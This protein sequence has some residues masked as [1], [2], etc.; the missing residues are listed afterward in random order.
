MLHKIK[1]EEWASLD[2]S[3][4]PSRVQ[5]IEKENEVQIKLRVEN[6]G[7]LPK[8]DGRRVQENLENLG[9]RMEMV[10]LSFSWKRGR[11]TKFCE[12]LEFNETCRRSL[13]HGPLD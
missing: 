11:I 6:K 4:Q 9:R 13:E 1:K 12:L 3:F 8:L 10:S 5:K 2:S 7:H